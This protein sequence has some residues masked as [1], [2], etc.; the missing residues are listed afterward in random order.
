MKNMLGVA[1]RPVA[2]R[3]ERLVARRRSSCRSPHYNNFFSPSRQKGSILERSCKTAQPRY[4][5][6]ADTKLMYMPGKLHCTRGL[7]REDCQCAPDPPWDPLPVRVRSTFFVDPIVPRGAE[8]ALD[9][10]TASME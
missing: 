9:P 2:L 6:S 8:P 10:S 4:S 7:S 1:H 3:Q 5:S